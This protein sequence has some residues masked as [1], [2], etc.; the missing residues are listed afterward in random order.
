MI[1][2]KEKKELTVISKFRENEGIDVK[3]TLEMAFK[4][5]YE[6]QVNKKIKVS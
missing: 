4:I 3:D 1:R 6:M 5:Y 2:G